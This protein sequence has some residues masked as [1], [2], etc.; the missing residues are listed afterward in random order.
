LGLGLAFG[1]CWLIT[2][3]LKL[4][5]ENEELRWISEGKMTPN[6]KYDQLTPK[7]LRVPRNIPVK[8]LGTSRDHYSIF[9]II[10]N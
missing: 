3:Y 1:G 9:T 8:S 2:D 7:A 6:D 10:K 4:K 5:K